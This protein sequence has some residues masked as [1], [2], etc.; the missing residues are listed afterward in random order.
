MRKNISKH[1][2]ARGVP[3]LI[4]KSNITKNQLF[5]VKAIS[6]SKLLLGKKASNGDNLPEF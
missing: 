5:E 1:Y 4:K 2:K 6:K 3:I